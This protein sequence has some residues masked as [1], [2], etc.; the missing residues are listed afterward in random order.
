MDGG[1]AGDAAR[2]QADGGRRSLSRER[3]RERGWCV[4]QLPALFCFQAS[5]LVCFTHTHAPT[6]TPAKANE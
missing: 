4:K 1:V 2:T 3:E 6:L 5:L